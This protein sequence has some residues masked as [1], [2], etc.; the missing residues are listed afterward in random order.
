MAAISRDFVTKN[1]IVIEGDSEVTSSTNQVSALQAAGGAAIAK[2]L[3]VGSTAT[4]YGDTNLI[5][6]LSVGSQTNVSGS[7]FPT[8]GGL[9]L[10]TL[11]QP[12]SKLYLR[13]NLKKNQQYNKRANFAYP[14]IN[15]LN[16][17]TK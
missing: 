17:K 16:K 3:I 6:S 1:G 15:T 4:I 5:G 8:V 7:I 10:G 13:E 11:A 9:D 2:N 12:F 14:I